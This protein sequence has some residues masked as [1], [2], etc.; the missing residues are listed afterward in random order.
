MEAANANARGGPHNLA[1]EATVA[2]HRAL[3]A[4]IRPS[5]RTAARFALVRPK[6]PTIVITNHKRGMVLAL[7]KTMRK[8]IH[9][10]A[11]PKDVQLHPS[12]ATAYIQ[13]ATREHRGET[14]QET[15]KRS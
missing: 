9:L 6:Q 7:W 13:G 1:E 4:M 2:T 3:H 15:T 11:R 5:A 12:D 8:G 14:E 10:Q